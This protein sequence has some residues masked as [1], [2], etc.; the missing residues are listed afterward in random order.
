MTGTEL[1]AFHNDKRL[2]SALWRATRRFTNDVHNREEYMQAA[3]L[4]IS[5]MAGGLT[6]REYTD[7]GE[8][9]IKAA[10]QRALYHVRKKTGQ[11]PNGYSVE[12]LKRTCIKIP[13]DE[14]RCDNRWLNLEPVELDPWYFQGEWR[15]LGLSSDAILPDRFYQIIIV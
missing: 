15:E 4:R 6:L 5:E 8:R 12:K 2:T 14:C 3:W 7:E 1:A 11:N 10:Y 13:G 9:A